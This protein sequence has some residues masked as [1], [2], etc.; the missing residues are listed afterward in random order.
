V[1]KREIKEKVERR[2]AAL[3]SVWK[4][5]G[6]SQLYAIVR[7]DA[8]DDELSREIGKNGDPIELEDV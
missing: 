8:L 4:A 5:R 6:S 3:Q 2:G 7:V 1:R